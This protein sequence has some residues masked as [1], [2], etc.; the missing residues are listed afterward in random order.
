MDHV[1]N[2]QRSKANGSCLICG[3]RKVHYNFSLG[4]F[5]IEECANCGLMRL[6][7]RPTAQEL[8]TIYPSDDVG[9]DSGSDAPQHVSRLRSLTA[10]YYLGLLEAYVGRTLK[11]RLLEIGCGYGD[12]LVRAADRGLTVTGLDYSANAVRVPLDRLKGRAQVICGDLGQLLAS[13]D[14]F[15]FVVFKDSLE[16]EHD[17]TAFLQN[18]H[19]LLDENG[20]AMGIVP[21]LDSVSARLMR[22]RWPEFKPE[23][24]WY[25]S[26][27]TLTRLLHVEGFGALRTIQAKKALSID[28]VVE[29]FDRYVLPSFLVNAVRLVRYVLPQVLRQYP[30]HFSISEMIVLATRQAIRDKKRLSVV[31]PAYDEVKS[32]RGA[33]ERVLAK[34]VDGVDIDLIIVESNSRDGTREIVREHEGRDRVKVIWQERP[35]GKGNA[36]RTGLQHV[37]GDYILI[38][39]ADDEYDIE[40]YDALLEPLITGE[41]TF[42]LGARHGGGAWKMRQFDDQR[43]AAHLLNLGH[44]FFVS[45]VNVVYGL[46]LKDPFTM[47]KVFR[48]DCLRGLNFECDRFDFDFE[49]L[50]KLVRTGHKP[51]EIPVNYRG[52]SFKEGKKIDVYRDPW[53]WLRAVAKYRLQKF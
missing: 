20:V 38:Q 29:R 22:S 35:R 49:L 28:Y 21:S 42:V 46:R 26:P 30:F 1:L 52:R 16:R 32:I 13:G 15:D 43:A 10:D 5:R 23:H 36:V 25:F 33:I 14:R 7:P 19:E 9:R 31:M 3:G 4:K 8:A 27:A 51:I 11:G 17:P 53:T 39:D 18:V 24:L 40:D 44:R 45:L 6:N 47:Y 41:A 50:I 12:F 37:G 2:Q 48:A 34:K